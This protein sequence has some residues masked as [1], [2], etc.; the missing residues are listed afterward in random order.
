MKKAKVISGGDDVQDIRDIW[1]QEEMKIDDLNQN[2][3][4]GYLTA[5]RAE[6]HSDTA[7]T[8]GDAAAKQQ[9]ATDKVELSSYNS[10]TAGST[11][12]HE[13]RTSR[14]EELRAQIAN[15]SYQVSGRAVAEKMLSKIVM[16]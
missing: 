1:G 4:V 13:I 7:D 10:A 2:A 6:K 14:V 16:H 12:G 9:P 8:H 5:A 15:G 11:Q 3:A